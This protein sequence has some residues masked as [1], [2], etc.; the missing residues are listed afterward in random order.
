MLVLIYPAFR[1]CAGKWKLC[2]HLVQLDVYFLG[3]FKENVTISTI[4]QL[5][6]SVQTVHSFTVFSPFIFFGR[7]PSMRKPGPGTK[8]RT[9][10]VTTLDPKPTEPQEN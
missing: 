2:C 7:T 10:A 5:F 9:T 8:P 3:F 4:R 6:F 1:R